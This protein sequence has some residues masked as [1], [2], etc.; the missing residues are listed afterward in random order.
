R[1]G[2][3]AAIRGYPDARDDQRAVRAIREVAQYRDSREAAIIKCNRRVEIPC[4][5]AFDGSIRRA[6]CEDRRSRIDDRYLL[7]AEVRIAAA[8][9]CF[10]DPCDDLRAIAGIGERAK[11]EYRF[12]AASVLRH[13]DIEL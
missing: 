13:R 12:Q 11:Y 2:I 5:A 8:I 4:G 7:A 3:A 6:Q 1:I 9:P 10:P